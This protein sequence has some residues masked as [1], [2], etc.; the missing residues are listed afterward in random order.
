MLGARQQELL[1]IL[2]LCAGTVVSAHRLAD[3]LWGE[4][5]PRAGAAGLCVSS[6]A[7]SCAAG[8]RRHAR[9]ASFRLRP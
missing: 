9:H 4:D 1:A 8:Q 7:V 2:L 5:Q 6:H 3:D